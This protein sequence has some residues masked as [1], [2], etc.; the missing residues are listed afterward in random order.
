MHL[1][2]VVMQFRAIFAD[3]TSA[4][5]AGAADAGLVHSWSVH[6]LSEYL[7]QLRAHLPRLAEGSALATVLEH[8]TYCGMSLGRVGIDFRPLLPALFEAPVE[9][10]FRSHLASASDG[11]EAALEAHRWVAL[12]PLPTPPQPAAA[13][14]GGG[15]GELA[16]PFSLMEHPPVAIFANGVL[17]AL[18]ELRHCA[19]GSLQARAAAA[20]QACLAA[21]ATSLL[22]YHSMRPTPL[23]DAQLA[24]FCALVAA[25]TEVA[26]PFLVTCFCRVYPENS[27][28]SVAGTAV[29]PARELLAR[30]AQVKASAAAAKASEAADAPVPQ[31]AAV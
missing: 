1:F 8:C 13:A 20:L 19:L 21:G 23:A 27:A 9:A 26:A 5:D 15:G 6:R 11:F 31:P 10:L 17:G 16:P 12:P 14:G 22:R 2:D 18:N 4:A 24:Q 3:E 29:A 25:F 30:L 28:A 7:H